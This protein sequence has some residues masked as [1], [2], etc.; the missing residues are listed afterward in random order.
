MKKRKR[1]LIIVLSMA[2]SLCLFGWAANAV[3]GLFDLTFRPWVYT[4]GLVVLP[5]LFIAALCLVISMLKSLAGRKDSKGQ[6]KT[7]FQK[8]GCWAGIVL[9]VCLIVLPA[10]LWLLSLVFSYCPEHKA[11]KDGKPMLAVVN[12]FL[13]VRVTYYDYKNFLVLGTGPGILE[14]F[15]KGGYDPFKREPAPTPQQTQ[16]SMP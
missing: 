16:T 2:L 12:S 8:A 7:V 4:A 6:Q 3:L 1:A 14:D 15:G 9:C 13:R 11:E 5:M 10:R